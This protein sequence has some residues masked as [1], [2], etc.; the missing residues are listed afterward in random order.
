M[1]YT[2]V[3]N[4]FDNFMAMIDARLRREIGLCHRDLSD[5]PYRDAFED[6]LNPSEVVEEV[7][8]QMD[9]LN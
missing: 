8:A 3:D 1:A 7:I 6:G 4:Q 5:Y 9:E 2:S